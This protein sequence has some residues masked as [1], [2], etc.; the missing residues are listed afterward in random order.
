MVS[1]LL[2][3]KLTAFQQ[4]LISMA[5]E[6]LTIELESA[7]LTD[8]YVAFLPETWKALHQASMVSLQGASSRFTSLHKHALLVEDAY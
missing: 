3:A 2:T 7:Q 4:G 6:A 1:S 5:Q 8:I